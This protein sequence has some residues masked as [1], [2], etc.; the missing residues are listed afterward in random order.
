MWRLGTSRFPPGQGA[1]FFLKTKEANKMT[2][3]FK[4]SKILFGL[5]IGLSLLAPQIV[6][7]AETVYYLFRHAEK[8]TEASDPGLTEEGYTRAENLAVF[9]GDLG[10]IE[11][12]SSDYTRTRDT[13][14]PLAVATGIAVEI[15]DPRDLEGFAETLRG[16]DGVI[17]IV[18]HSNTTPEL[19]ALL[20]GQETEPMPETEYDRL[21]EVLVSDDGIM[22]LNVLTQGI[23]K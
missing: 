2:H 6:L 19:T 16:L 12:Y 9:F 18:G 14:A 15:Y 17:I 13:V 3:F 7:A 21:Y 10:V 8:T 20:T 5:I 1:G 23:G 11:I 22:T 4:P